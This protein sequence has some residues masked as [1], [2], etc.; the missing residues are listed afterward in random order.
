MLQTVYD[1][2]TKSVSLQRPLP[3]RLKLMLAL[4]TLIMAAFALPLKAQENA[5]PSGYPLPRFASLRSEPINV[6]KGPGIRYEVAWVFVKE[7]LP[8]EIIQEFDTWRKIRDLDGQEGWIHQNLL[9]GR[10]TGYIAP[11]NPEAKVPILAR[12]S[13]RLADLKI[14]DKNQ[15]LRWNCLRNFRRQHIR[16]RP[17]GLFRLCRTVANLGRLSQRN[18]QMKSR[19]GLRANMSIYEKEFWCPGEDSNFHFHTETS[20]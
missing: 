1:H 20:T 7:G 9:S 16:H 3:A 13:K 19:A 17:P 8:V 14:S 10:R 15:T 4:F 5:N 11:W 2:K 18:I 6:R 12:A